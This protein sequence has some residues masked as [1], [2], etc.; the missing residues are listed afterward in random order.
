[1][2]AGLFFLL[3]IVVHCLNAQALVYRYNGINNDSSI[4]SDFEKGSNEIKT[5]ILESLNHLNLYEYAHALPELYELVGSGQ[6]DISIWKNFV[7]SLEEKACL[8][9][10]DGKEPYW[11]VDHLGL[12]SMQTEFFLASLEKS[13]SLNERYPRAF[14][15]LKENTQRIEDFGYKEDDYDSLVRFSDTKGRTTF[16]YFFQLEG[17]N[18]LAE[19]SKE[20][21]NKLRVI[22]TDYSIT[23]TYKIPLYLQKRKWQ[24]LARRIDKCEFI[25]QGLVD[26]MLKTID[27]A[28]Y[29]DDRSYFF[30]ALKEG[31][32]R[33]RTKEF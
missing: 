21:I 12:V 7:D 3:I 10:E 22:L 27:Y 20:D 33:N 2:K 5:S 6:L 19:R 31:V 25:E 32:D 9:M 4:D 18:L 23:S 29:D 26:I 24:S 15:L 8:F 30:R 11:A 17:C 28:L 1:M 16:W 13:K 14:K